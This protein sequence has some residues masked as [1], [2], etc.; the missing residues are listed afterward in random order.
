MNTS[1]E[2]THALVSFTK[3]ILESTQGRSSLQ[4]IEMI[5]VGAILVFLILKKVFKQHIFNVAKS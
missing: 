4:F 2:D 3:R 5:T 1:C